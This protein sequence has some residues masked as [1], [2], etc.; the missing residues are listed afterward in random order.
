[1]PQQDANVR[2]DTLAHRRTVPKALL[3]S[4]PLAALAVFFFLVGGSRR[5]GVLGQAVLDLGLDLRQLFRLRLEVAGMG[6]LELGFQRAAD[7]P[8]GV[9]EM[10]VDGGILGLEV[11]RALEILHRVLEIADAIVG[12]TK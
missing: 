12:P 5:R 1:M 11:D 4:R 10:V 9:A 6:P 3:I 8:I 2:T 7:A